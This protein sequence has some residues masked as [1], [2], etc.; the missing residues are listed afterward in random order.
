[1]WRNPLLHGTRFHTTSGTSGTPLRIAA[2]ISERAFAHANLEEWFLRITGN[3]WPKTLNLSGFMVPSSNS[4][5]VAWPDKLSGDT[6]LSIYSMKNE[7]LKPIRA[8]IERSKPRMIYG[9]ASAVAELAALLAAEPPHGMVNRV[10]ITTS[11]ILNP[12]WRE[13]IEQSLA[14]R[15]YDLYGSQEGQHLVVECEAGA[16]HVNPLIGIVEIVDTAGEPC[17]PGEAGRVIVTGL[18]TASMPLFRYE[19]GDIAVA[20]PLTIGCPCG[21][22]WATIG[23]I[24]GRTEDLVVT[25]DGR[26]IGYL[27]FHATKNKPQIKE[28]QLVQR[29]YDQF[30]F[31][32]VCRTNDK[33]TGELET[34][35]AREIVRRLQ[36]AANIDF[37]YLQEIPKGPNGKF[38]AVKVEFAPDQ[39][40]SPRSRASVA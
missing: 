7:N 10:A 13:L 1:M 22:Q 19:L 3:R 9:Y 35:L 34:S 39:G 15:V 23:S 25:P 20:S 6:Y 40:D 4:G 14:R 21:S 16:M 28:A 5:E 33:E 36:Y 38:R 32:L 24:Q 26:R 30:V 27:C 18:A 17:R 12:D 11:E 37:E 29:G 31:R 8:E 2:T